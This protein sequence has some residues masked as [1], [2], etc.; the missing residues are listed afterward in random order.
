MSE[1]LN[2]EFGGLTFDEWAKLAKSSPDLFALK[3]LE[4]TAEHIASVPEQ[5]RLR[6]EQLQFR[7]NGLRAKYGKCP[8]ASAQV[9]QDE[10]FASLRCL[11]GEL[12][13]LE[14]LLSS[15]PEGLRSVK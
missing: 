10:M 13:E 4:V 15:S 1:K 11:G 6:L 7:V 2:P 9:L 5:Y 12:R 8:L 3:R 14:G